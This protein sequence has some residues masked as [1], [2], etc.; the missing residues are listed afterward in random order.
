MWTTPQARDIL[1][2]CCER[3]LPI[4]QRSTGWLPSRALAFFPELH[5]VGWQDSFY[6][7]VIFFLMPVL[8][9]M[10][11]SAEAHEK[12]R[13]CIG[14]GVGARNEMVGLF[15]QDHRSGDIS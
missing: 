7:R 4:I 10:A 3:E 5:A 1:F 12:A 2:E 6:K 11:G 8:P 9:A 13:V 15:L 14:N